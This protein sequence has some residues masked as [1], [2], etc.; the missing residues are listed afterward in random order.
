MGGWERG[1]AVPVGRQ[2]G[3]GGGRGGCE[4][5]GK[6]GGGGR[7]DPERAALADHAARQE[8]VN[9]QQDLWQQHQMLEMIL[10]SRYQHLHA[11]R[12]RRQNKGSM[13]LMELMQLEW[14]G[15]SLFS[16]VLLTC[17][18]QRHQPRLCDG[19]RGG[20]L[21]VMHSHCMRQL[22]RGHARCGQIRRRGALGP[23]DLEVVDV[24]RV[25]GRLAVRKVEPAR[26]SVGFCAGAGFLPNRTR[27]LAAV[28]ANIRNSGPGGRLI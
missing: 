10:N 26:R 12:A 3:G 2:Q 21:C 22:P 24:A 17:S 15:S 14:R 11:G 28:H 8:E 1:A 13:Q 5:A 23:H 18:E 27:I 4:Q 25:E 9:R 20:R 7:H 16:S 19:V 6:D